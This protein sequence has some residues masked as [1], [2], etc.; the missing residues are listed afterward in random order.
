[1]GANGP[2]TVPPTRQREV[3]MHQENMDG[4]VQRIKQKLSDLENRIEPVLVQVPG[5][6]L[7]DN[8]ATAQTGL[9]QWFTSEEKVL[10]DIEAK[11]SSMLERLEL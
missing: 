6:N 10:A 8:G 9:G 1:M 11:L 2:A 3:A 5:E 4:L 7:K